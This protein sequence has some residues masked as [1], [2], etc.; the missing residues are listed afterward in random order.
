MGEEDK[1]RKSEI[2]V[3][4]RPKLWQLPT[5]QGRGKSYNVSVME[6]MQLWPSNDEPR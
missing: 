5:K 4:R 3:I 2:A 1:R 6:G